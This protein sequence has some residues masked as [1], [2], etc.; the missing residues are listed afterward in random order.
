MIHLQYC[1]MKPKETYLGLW[2]FLGCD[3]YLH[4]SPAHGS[5][6]L[7]G[8]SCASP[9]VEYSYSSSCYLAVAAHGGF[10]IGV[11]GCCVRL[12]GK[13]HGLEMGK[14]AEGSC[15]VHSMCLRHGRQSTLFLVKI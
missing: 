12:C 9:L 15:C 3:C 6:E 4:K 8:L 13:F 2:M 10:G 7:F 11:G 5:H 14:C 1:R